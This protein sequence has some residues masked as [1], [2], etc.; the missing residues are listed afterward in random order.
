MQIKMNFMDVTKQVN[1]ANVIHKYCIYVDKE[2]CMGPSPWSDHH[3]C[4]VE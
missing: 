1:R 2:Q 3:H 4:R